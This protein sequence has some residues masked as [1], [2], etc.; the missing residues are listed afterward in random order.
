MP[1]TDTNRWSYLTVVVKYVFSPRVRDARGSVMCSVVLVVR[2]AQM[3]AAR[4]QKER[5]FFVDNLL[6]RIHLI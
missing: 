1:L 4:K 6:V 3:V 5:E 2:D